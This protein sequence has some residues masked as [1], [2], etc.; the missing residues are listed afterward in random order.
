MKVAT[1]L[2]TKYLHLIKDDDYHM[3]LAHLIGKDKEYTEFYKTMCADPDKYVIMDNGLI[4]GDP[5]PIE[6]LVEKALMIGATEIILPDVF[7]DTEATLEAACYAMEYLEA[8]GRD[9]P[10]KV[11]AV[12]QGSTI[13]EWLYCAEQMI[14]WDIDCLG[15][16]KVLVA[17]NGRDGRLDALQRL[18]NKLRGLDIHLLGCWTNALE[19]TLIAKAEYEGIIRP[20]RGVDSALAYYYT[21]EGLLLN[22]CDKPSGYVNF[23][24]KSLD[25]DLLKRNIEM[26]KDACVVNKHDN[27]VTKLFY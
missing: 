21:K 14:E 23:A 12:P 13:E 25:E 16:P 7:K 18:G 2:P 10:F 8:Y 6:E 9:L 27:K 11:M 19:L 1:I 15:I 17:I 4:E 26:W 5:R 3:C 20:I 22:Q 24:D